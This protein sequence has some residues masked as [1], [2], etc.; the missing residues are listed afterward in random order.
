M[1][2]GQFK[3]L[4]K[5]TENS[6]FGNFYKLSHSVALYLWINFIQNF[7]EQE[8]LLTRTAQRVRRA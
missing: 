4:L 8:A 3:Q 5:M 1:D 7:K 2:F 6:L